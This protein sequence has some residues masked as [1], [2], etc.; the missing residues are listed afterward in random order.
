MRRHWP[1]ALGGIRI[2]REGVISAAALREVLGDVLEP[3]T[4]VLG[5]AVVNSSDVPEVR[6]VPKSE[7]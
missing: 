4:E 1:A 6:D 7:A 3:A 5:G 2:L